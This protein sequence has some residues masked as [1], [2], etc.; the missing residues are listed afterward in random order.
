[1]ILVRLT[2]GEKHVVS[3]IAQSGAPT[4]N[5]QTLAGPRNIV[6]RTWS[7]WQLLVHMVE[8]EIFFRKHR[9]ALYTA[10]GHITPTPPF[11]FAQSLHFLGYFAPMQHEH[12][13]SAHTLTKAIYADGQVIVFQLTS[14]GT[15]EAPQLAYTLY[16]QQPIDASTRSAA[17]DRI[18]FFLSLADDLRPF[19]LTGRSDPN[20]AAI[21]E[22]LYGYHQVKFVTPF[23]SAC[24]AILSQRNLLT[25]A[26]KMKQAL[27]ERFGGSLDV[28]GTIYWAF[29]EPAPLALVSEG[30]LADVIGNIRKGE[31]LSAVARAFSEVDEEFLRTASY[32]EV[33]TWL[34]KIK[35]IG[36]W[37][38]QFILLRGLGRTEHVPLSEKKLLQ[39]VSR[40]YGRG[41]EMTSETL[42][43]I[44]DQYSTWQGYWAHY[45]R[46]AS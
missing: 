4:G 24:W 9:L 23:E 14:T 42:Q 45:L 3:I 37:S 19:Y 34:R 29:P 10:T 15:I 2:Q 7:V 38:A 41:Q 20:F 30:E 35:G 12:T 18:T 40:T 22:Q 6:W 26:Q 31:Q 39:A 43:R 1:M 32:D 16:S 25:V 21:I 8:Y 33:E 36:T 11:D 5:H 13:L 44:A 17:I 46:V 28:D 27:A